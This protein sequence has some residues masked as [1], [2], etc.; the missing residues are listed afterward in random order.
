MLKKLKSLF[1]VDDEEFKKKMSGQD[2]DVSEPI[3]PAPKRTKNPSPVVKSSAS[4]SGKVSDKF[5][6][7]LMSALDQNNLDGFDYLEFKKSLRNLE[8]MNMDDATRF[9]SAFAMAQTLNATPDNLIKTA[10]HYLDVLSKEEVK[11]GQA[12][13]NQKVK[14]IQGK[15]TKLED[16]DKKIRTKADQIKK[17]S[18]DI[19]QHQQ[20]M[21][22]LRAEIEQSSSKVLGTQADF[23]ASYKTVVSQI[24]GDVE[25]M[26]QYLK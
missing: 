24:Q 3:K 2:G 16:L 17:L 12:L 6:N 18:K 10:K 9:K 15:Q 21:E 4:A 5:L 1:V 23:M 20:Q 7:I 13:E 25:K 22:G 11:F 14:Q 26:K 8:K 19:E